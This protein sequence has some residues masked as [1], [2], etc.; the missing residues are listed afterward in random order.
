MTDPK[1]PSLRPSRKKPGSVLHFN[2]PVF[3]HFKQADLVCRAR[4][5]TTLMFWCLSPSINKTAST[6]CSRIFGPARLLF[7]GDVAHDDQRYAVFLG[8]IDQRFGAKMITRL[9]SRQSKE[10]SAKE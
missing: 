3:N 4:L 8:Q 9:S 7:F 1:L 6:M 2:K 5:R 10:Y